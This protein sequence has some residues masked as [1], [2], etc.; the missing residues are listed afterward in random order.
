M[1]E[2][3]SKKVLPN[4]LQIIY[5]QNII[6]R[7]ILSIKRQKKCHGQ[8][9]LS[10]LRC[11]F[12]SVMIQKIPIWKNSTIHSRLLEYQESGDP[13]HAINTDI[14]W[15][16]T[17]FYVEKSLYWYLKDALQHRTIREKFTP[18]FGLH[19]NIS[20]CSGHISFFR[21]DFKR[22]QLMRHIWMNR[23]HAVALRV[24]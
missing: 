23:K 6:R 2:N 13:K 18:I 14:P 15:G 4:I 1:H 19:G 8:Y 5:M 9:Q 21:H 3:Q 22:Q 24:S 16:Y 10:Y 20:K 17:K 12:K 11:T 7:Y